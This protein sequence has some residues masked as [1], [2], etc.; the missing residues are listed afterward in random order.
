MANVSFARGKHVKPQ[1]FVS[2]SSPAYEMPIFLCNSVSKWV[3]YLSVVSL[4]GDGVGS[5]VTWVSTIL[6]DGGFTGLMIFW[7]VVVVDNSFCSV[8]IAEPA[9]E[10]WPTQEKQHYHQIQKTGLQSFSHTERN[11][12]QTIRK[13]VGKINWLAI[14]DNSYNTQWFIYWW[15]NKRVMDKL[16]DRCYVE[17]YCEAEIWGIEGGFLFLD[18]TG[19]KA[20]VK[21]EL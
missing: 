9:L 18:W 6:C 14:S 19:E 12:Q 17:S 3:W 16:M 20:H 7:E 1:T 8:A 11:G 13:K 2:H 4:K 21:G 15:F 5:G 10:T